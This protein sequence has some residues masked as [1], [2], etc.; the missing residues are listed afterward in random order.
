MENEPMIQE[1]EMKQPLA[2]MAGSL[3][4]FQFIGMTPE[5]EVPVPNPNSIKGSGEAHT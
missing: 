2:R 1:T 5:Q 4:S 3:K